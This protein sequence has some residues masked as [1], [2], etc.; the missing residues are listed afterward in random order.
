MKKIFTLFAA[1]ML[2]IGAFAQVG[3]N[4]TVCV[5]LT[6]PAVNTPITAI[7]TYYAN[8]GSNSITQ[9]INAGATP[10]NFCFP[11]YL[12]VPD[13]GN[14][15]FVYGTI[16]LSNCNPSNTVS[17]SQMITA[18]ATINVNVQNCSALGGCGV[19]ISPV[20]GSTMVQANATGVAPF[21]YSWDGGITYT[22]N[23]TYSPNGANFVCVTVIDFTGCQA[24]DCDTLGSL[25]PTCSVYASAIPDSSNPGY[26]FF[27]C[28]PNGTGPYTYNWLFSD[29]SASSAQNPYLNLNNN[30]GVNWGFVTV[31]DANG[32]VSYYSVSVVLPNNNNNCNAYFSMAANYS[33]GTPGEIF[34]QDQSFATGGVQSY[35]WDFGDNSSSTQAN[36]NHTYA[37]AGYYNVCLTVTGS[38]GCTAT[39]CTNTYVNPAWWN[40]SP[41]QGSCT[42]GFLIIP[43]PANAGMVNIINTSQGNNLDYIWDFGN[44]TTATGATPFFSYTNSG[45][46]QICLTIIDSSANCLDTF[47][48]TITIDSLGNVSRSPISGN[49]GVVVHA[50]A[51][52]NDLLSVSQINNATELMIA[53]NPSNGLVTLTANWNE[54]G[55]V[56]VEVIDISGKL[57]YAQSV[58][59]NKG[60]SKTTIDLGQLTAGS[61]LFR[62]ISNDTISTSRLMIQ[63]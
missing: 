56:N 25:N 18:D 38:N 22:S 36:P 59:V 32:C 1:M 46:Y 12:H 63:K 53:P 14:T 13:S 21:T 29:G 55:N 54:A 34:F 3:Y 42:A 39:W 40:S 57:V 47:C 10:I 58:K 35:A 62:T 8:G 24:T 19:S 26:V 44:G 50:T 15:A 61:Y 16:Q 30:T 37:A 52:P 28:F 43:G 33:T 11:A 5:N 17:Y 4:V 27:N 20:L 51:Q 9:T 60:N 41:F 45:T 23:N 7:L 49:V 48:D 2:S 31:T 6:G